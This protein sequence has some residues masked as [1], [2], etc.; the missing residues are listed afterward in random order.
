ML[1]VLKSGIWAEQNG[2]Y[3]QDFATVSDFDLELKIIKDII[4][5]SVSPYA[6]LLLQKSIENE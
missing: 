5:T 6:T 3:K 4:L 1:L 2:D